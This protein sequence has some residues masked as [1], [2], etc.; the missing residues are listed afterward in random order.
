MHHMGMDRILFLA[1]KV[2]PNI[3]R[4]EI[5]QIIRTCDRCQSINPSLSAGEIQV[6]KNWERLAIDVNYYRNK[7]Y[8]SLVDCSSGRFAIWKRIWG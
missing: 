4:E 7:V 6:S 3:H 2:I 5:R 1:R 8:L